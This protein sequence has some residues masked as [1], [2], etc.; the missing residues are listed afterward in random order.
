MKDRSN[1]ENKLPTLP[2]SLLYLLIQDDLLQELEDM[3]QQ[4]LEKDLLSVPAP[5]GGENPLDQL[6]DIRK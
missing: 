3:E 1:V 5:L 2:F 6:P 4:D